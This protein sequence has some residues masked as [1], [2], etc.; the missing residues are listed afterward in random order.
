MT[1][2]VEI[3]RADA[4]WEASYSAALRAGGMGSGVGWVGAGRGLPCVR[5]A[6]GG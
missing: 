5:R 1:A 3:S 4:L 6:I 2:P